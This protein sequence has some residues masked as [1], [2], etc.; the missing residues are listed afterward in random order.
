MRVSNRFNFNNEKI[1]VVL[2]LKIIFGIIK[3]EDF[4]KHYILT[5][6]NFIISEEIWV[7]ERF[8]FFISYDFIQFWVY[9]NWFM[10]CKTSPIHEENVSLKEKN[11]SNGWTEYF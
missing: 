6:K 2:I 7:H 1:Q 11:K 9:K 10:L 8:R 3:S 5:F 4:V